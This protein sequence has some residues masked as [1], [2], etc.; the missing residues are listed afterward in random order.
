MCRIDAGFG[1][2]SL[3]EKQD[4][5]ERFIQAL[6]DNHAE[7]KFRELLIKHFSDN[8]DRVFDGIDRFEE[9]LE[10]ADNF[11]SESDQCVAVLLSQH[12]QLLSDYHGYIVGL[13]AYNNALY[14][15]AKDVAH[16]YF[17]NEPYSF[18]VALSKE[19]R[20]Y[21]FQFANW[22]YGEGFCFS[23]TFFNDK[24]L[25]LL[26]EEDRTNILWGYFESIMFISQHEKVLG[27]SLTTIA[28][29][30][31]IHGPLPKRAFEILRA[32]SFIETWIKFDAQSGK[33]QSI[34]NGVLAK[35]NE[36]LTYLARS[37]KSTNEKASEVVEE[38]LEDKKLIF[39]KVYYLN[40]DLLNASNEEREAWA[41]GI[42]R[43]YISIHSS[44]SSKVPQ[45]E[46]SDSTLFQGIDFDHNSEV[47]RPSSIG[48]DELCVQLNDFQLKTWIDCSI[49]NDLRGIL[50][51]SRSS[52][53]DSEKWIHPNYF[54][55]WKVT[56]SNKI[57]SLSIE[58][59]LIVLARIPP[60]QKV[61]DT[62][63]FVHC[64]DLWCGLLNGLVKKSDFPKALIPDWALVASSRL[65]SKTVL[66][67]LDKSIGMLR[68]KLNQPEL[69]EDDK[70]TYYDQLKRL[71]ELLDGSDANKALRHRLL[72][73][74]SSNMALSDASLSQPFD[75]FGKNPLD[76]YASLPDLA[77]K[78]QSKMNGCRTSEEL[79]QRQEAFLLAVT[80]QV[81]EFCL[82]R[83]R[84]RKGEKTKDNQYE[85]SQVVESSPIWRQGY[86]K[87]LSELGF[88]LN[89]KVHK[90]VNF[91][92]KSD[93]DENVRAIAAECYKSVRR[94][95]KKTPSIIE[96]K[97]GLI[98]AEWW[99][100]LSQRKAL[101]LDVDDK[102]ALKTRRRLMRNP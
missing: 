76:W 79:A 30:N 91:I 33:L 45:S 64:Y 83:L 16:I 34:W 100:L 81:A 73:M 28:F 48:F 95:S 94:N 92:N 15:F 75:P 61:S 36:Y 7:G 66:S 49:N 35:V 59:Q 56:F 40:V 57:N 17:P 5:K 55:E 50:N 68:G 2:G 90:T 89:G 82:S 88:D 6:Y 47:R 52:F 20:L 51:S 25:S 93:P 19:L 97:R 101:G 53:N 62:D 43:Y 11:E 3:D 70:N 84:L 60:S 12:N 98:A 31:V 96:L 39:Q 10:E 102:E 1:N 32:L 63:N 29:S 38:W 27:R 13:P 41:N 87:A 67:Y 8:W 37:I 26:D 4:P 65:E 85:S 44:I 74:R 18:F 86:L 58:E 78:F 9:A 23:E 14:E 24:A 42:D 22:L 99:L 80:H 54:E 77:R 71:L 69:S 72:L 21:Y 46:K